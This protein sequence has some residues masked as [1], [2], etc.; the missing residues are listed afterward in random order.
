MFNPN[1]EIKTLEALSFPY[2]HESPVVIE[3]LSLVNQAD[4]GYSILITLGFSLK[5]LPELFIQTAD[6]QLAH[7]LI[8]HFHNLHALG[9]ISPGKYI[10]DGYDLKQHNCDS[11]VVISKAPLRIMSPLGSLLQDVIPEKMKEAVNHLHVAGALEIKINPLIGA[12]HRTAV[13]S[14]I[15]A[16]ELH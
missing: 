16:V 4:P 1:E 13:P 10:L 8:K 7:V 5:G 2:Y 3:I 6:V 11:N 12:V 9:L 14:V 15:G